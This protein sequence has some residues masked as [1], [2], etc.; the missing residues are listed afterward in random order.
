MET[1]AKIAE[2]LDILSALLAPKNNVLL[3]RAHRL[4]ESAL[5]DYFAD[6]DDTAALGPTFPDD[7]PWRD[8]I[9]TL[10]AEPP[11]PEPAA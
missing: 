6:E 8:E 11:R 9:I 7:E 3:L 1:R 2:A 5:Q 10:S 4:L